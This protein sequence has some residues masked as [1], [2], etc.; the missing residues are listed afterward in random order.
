MCEELGW[1]LAAFK[2]CA[3]GA[4]TGETGV[5]RG[6]DLF[7]NWGFRKRQEQGVV[8][9][10][11]G[12]LAVGIEAADRLDLIPEEV[13]ADGPIHLWR[14]DVEDAAAEG[15]LPGHLDDV[16]FGVADG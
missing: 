16:D 6:E 2:C 3:C 13:D 8:K 11:G 9:G 5:D 4:C 7:R 15:D 10:G 12:A 14:V 1:L